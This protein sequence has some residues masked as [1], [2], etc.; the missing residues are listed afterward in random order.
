MSKPGYR[1][2]LHAVKAV[3]QRC[4]LTGKFD[5]GRDVIH[6]EVSRELLS[7]M[8]GKTFHVTAVQVPEGAG[9][10]TT[11]VGLEPVNLPMDDKSPKAA[12]ITFA[13]L[14]EFTT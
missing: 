7:G 2:Q 6:I 9:Y 11:I 12:V 10:D 8:I 14:E 5:I 4:V 3:G 13:E 1:I